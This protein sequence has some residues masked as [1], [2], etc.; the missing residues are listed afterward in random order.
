MT[1]SKD[2]LLKRLLHALQQRHTHWESLNET[3]RVMMNKAVDSCMKDCI[4]ADF[5]Q[6]AI[7]TVRRWEVGRQL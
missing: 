5:A 4:N 1:T 7:N 3:D 2:E 6:A